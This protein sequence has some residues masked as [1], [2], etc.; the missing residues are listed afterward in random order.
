MPWCTTWSKRLLNNPLVPE[1]FELFLC[2]S[3]E[4]SME[5]N[6]ETSIRAGDEISVVAFESES[7]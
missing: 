3:L 7:G 1:V 6:I 5:Q 2:W 4:A